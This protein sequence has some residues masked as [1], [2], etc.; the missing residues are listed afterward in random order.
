MTELKM[1]KLL[2]QS[3][4]IE[5]ERMCIGAKAYVGN[6]F[7]N[8]NGKRWNKK[9]DLLIFHNLWIIHPRTKKEILKSPIGIEFKNG[10]K[11]NQITIGVLNQITKRY[12]NE[13]YYLNNNKETT[14]K[15]GSLAFATTTSCSTGTVYATNYQEASNFFIERFCWRAN[16][17]VILKHNDEFVF[18]FVNYL[19]ALNG[20]I[21]GRYGKHGELID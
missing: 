10:N 16:V 3:L 5:F 21:K 20:N 14:F 18:S 17:A 9:P 2:A 7:K 11:F 15:L 4:N 1:Q 6:E 13:T 12:S 8:S 19:F